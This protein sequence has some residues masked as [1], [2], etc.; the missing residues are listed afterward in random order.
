MKKSNALLGILFVIMALVLMVGCYNT[1]TIE[2]LDSSGKVIKRTTVSK[3]VTA[4]KTYGAAGSVSAVKI[5]SAGSTA[6]GTPLPN[7]FMGGGNTAFASTPS[8][9]NRPV[10]IYTS[11]CSILGSLTSASAK[12]I[13]FI[14]FG[15]KGEKASETVSRLTAFLSFF[16]EDAT[17]TESDAVDSGIATDTAATTATE[18]KQ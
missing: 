9:E 17:L 8:E 12:S 11:S 1:A 16:G 18:A 15:L 7:V 10:V 3:P 14:Y 6:T 5:D 2:T 4:D 13:S